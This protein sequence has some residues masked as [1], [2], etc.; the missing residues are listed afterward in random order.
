MRGRTHVVPKCECVVKHTPN[1]YQW[2]GFGLTCS[3]GR[4]YPPAYPAQDGPGRL[5][6]SERPS[7]RASQKGTVTTRVNGTC[8]ATHSQ[9][10]TTCVPYR[11]EWSPTTT[12]TLNISRWVLIRNKTDTQWSSATTG[13]LDHYATAKLHT[14]CTDLIPRNTSARPH[15]VTR[16]VLS[17]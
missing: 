13:L 11:T 4:W 17:V 16:R 10:G 15:T 14:G 8:S 12:D 3:P 5:V 7:K 9:L 2:V 6:L 1:M